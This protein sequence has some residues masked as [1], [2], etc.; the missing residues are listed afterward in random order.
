M[1]LSQQKQSL[2][3]TDTD[4]AAVAA[5]GYHDPLFFIKYVLGKDK[6][7]GPIHGEMLRAL[8]LY[9]KLGL[10]YPRE[11]YKTTTVTVGYVIWRIIRNPDIRILIVH[12]PYAEGR[13][14]VQAIRSFFEINEVLRH[15]YGDFVRRKG[16]WGDDRFTVRTRKNITHEQTVQ[17]ASPGHDPVGGHFNIIICDDIVGLK[18]RYSEAERNIT[19][20]YVRSLWALLLPGGQFIDIGTRWHVADAHSTEVL[21]VPSEQIPRREDFF[22]RLKSAVNPDGSVYFPEQFNHERLAALKLGMGPALYSSQ[23][24]NTPMAEGLKRF[25][26]DKFHFYPPDRLPDV[27]RRAA[28]IDPA[29]GENVNK[30]DYTAMIVGYL[31]NQHVYVPAAVLVNEPF[32]SFA[33]RMIRLLKEHKVR[34]LYVEAN[35]FQIFF[36]KDCA[37]AIKKA[38]LTVRLHKVKQMRNKEERIDAIEPM[39]IGGQVI[40]R[41]DWITAYPLLITQLG[42][43]PGGAHDDGPDCL[44]GLLAALLGRKRIGRGVFLP[45]PPK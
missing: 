44:E 36:A 26:V 1:L 23:M 35:A 29:V 33:P 32:L 42:D 8:Q 39:V 40:F 38:G 6:L 14:Y 19:R 18:D 3:A 9:D 7:M 45:P 4:W 34:T 22:V 12:K 2:S 37:E 28:Y 5:R 13:G 17:L 15:C 27:A 24:L 31:A 11:H 21:G 30:G 20:R 43:F 16:R 10:F 25:D 41:D